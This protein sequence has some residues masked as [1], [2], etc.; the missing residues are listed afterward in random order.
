VEIMAWSPDG[1]LLATSCGPESEDHTVHIWNYKSESIEVSDITLT[2]TAP[3]TALAWSRDSQTV[4]VTRTD[5]TFATYN[6]GGELVVSQML[7]GGMAHD[8]A[9]DPIHDH[10]ALATSNGVIE[11]MH[12]DGTG[13]MTLQGHSGRV[14]DIDWSPN[15]ERLTAVAEDGTARCWNSANGET[16]WIFVPAGADQ[17][18]TLRP[19][20]VLL[21]RLAGTPDSAFIFVGGTEGRQE[22]HPCQ[23]GPAEVIWDAIENN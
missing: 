18:V 3:V 20:G 1:T 13:E 15:G 12:A 10:F 23:F 4:L 7:S 5:N 2:G 14:T 9:W 19:D 21:S 17:A 11:I 8:A 16:A 22:V 6:V